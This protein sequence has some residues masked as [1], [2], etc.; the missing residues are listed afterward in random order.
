LRWIA[1][2]VLIA[3]AGGVVILVTSRDERPSGP[4]EVWVP[5]TSLD[6]LGTM[7]LTISALDVRMAPGG[8]KLKGW[9]GV[10]S[11]SAR[12]HRPCLAVYPNFTWIERVRLRFSGSLSS[13]YIGGY[14][15]SGERREADGAAW[16]R[17]TWLDAK[18]VQGYLND[19]PAH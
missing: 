5:V 9:I 7:P 12:Q 10:W 4:S 11:R 6:R 1:A 13:A 17:M 2:I 15:D 18:G 16:A 3:F 8:P 14:G 19:E